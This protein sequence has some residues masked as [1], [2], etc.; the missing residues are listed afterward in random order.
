VVTLILLLPVLP[1]MN[2][3]R[4]TVEKTEGK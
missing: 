1:L 4:K 3:L 2:R